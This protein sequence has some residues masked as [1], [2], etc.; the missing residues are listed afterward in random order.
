MGKEDT[1]LNFYSSQ[2]SNQ[3]NKITKPLE[4]CFC[5]DGFFYSVT[6]PSGHGFQ[7]SNRPEVGNEYFS[8][9]HYKFNPFICHPDNYKHNQVIITQDYYQ[10]KFFEPYYKSIKVIENSFGFSNYLCIF[11]KQ[12]DVAHIFFYSSS[13]KNALLNTLFSRHLHAFMSFSDYFL[14][15]WSEHSKK[16]EPYLLNLGDL[17][18]S[19]F[20]KV[21]PNLFSHTEK[22]KIQKL[23]RQMGLLDAFTDIQLTKRESD[24]ILQLLKGKSAREISEALGITKRTVEHYLENIKQKFNC[25]NKSE[26]F[27]IAQELK[28][29]NLL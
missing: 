22:E 15:E 23:M 3:L 19:H 25:L 14:Q 1:L 27:A 12:G 28:N 17:M 9:Q 8:N 21:N 2:L 18:G 13:K 29:F 11:K 26:L 7:V 4:D 24:C 5:L 10:D 6:M 16:M 20:H